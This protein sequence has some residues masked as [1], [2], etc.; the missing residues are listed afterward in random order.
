MRGLAE[1][2]PELIRVGVKDDL[3]VPHRLPLIPNAMAAMSAAT[4]VGAW[5]VT[6]SGS[7]SGLIAMCDPDDAESIAS[8]MHGVFDAGGGDPECVGFAV[9]PCM[10]GLERLEP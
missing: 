7:G 2:D 3:H 5:A 6:I 9:R 1:G 10:E 8:V 4:D